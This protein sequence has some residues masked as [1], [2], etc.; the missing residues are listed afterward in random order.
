[1]SFLGDFFEPV[2][3]L[4][5]SVIGGAL[6]NSAT[7]GFQDANIA[8]QR[9]QLQNKHQWEVEDLRKAGLNPILSATNGSSAVSAGSPQGASVDIGKAL[10]A[11]SN[12]AL[13]RKQEQIA[14]YDAET[15]RISAN[16]QKLA[17]KVEESKA[18]S[19]IALN[20]SSRWL[21]IQNAERIGHLWPMEVAYAKA[22]VDYTVQKMINSII[23]VNA[24][25]AYFEKAGDAQL[26][27]GSA[28]QSQAAAAH[29]QAD[30]SA[31]IAATME[32]NGVSEREVNRWKAGDYEQQIRESVA[33]TGKILTE[34]KQLNFTLQKDMLHNPNYRRTDGGNWFTDAVYGT[35]EYLR[36][37]N[38][39][40]GMFG[41]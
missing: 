29:R 2:M 22:N 28:A 23:E 27:I 41:N 3:G 7:A 21:N 12:S 1:M 24:K 30:V 39:L 14:E 40:R 13:M 5:T 26:M 20:D 25:A 38:P 18:E 19:A 37:I 6:Q 36:E 16:A 15:R 4:A 10:E 9:E 32:K 31:Q 17:S 35:G 33:R 11:I 34:D 8:W